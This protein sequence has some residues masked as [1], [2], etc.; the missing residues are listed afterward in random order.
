MS[1]VSQDLLRHHAIDLSQTLRPVAEHGPA[2]EDCRPEIPPETVRIAK[3]M[4]EQSHELHVLQWQAQKFAARLSAE[5]EM[6]PMPLP[7]VR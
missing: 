7:H 1:V 6:P 2:C 4:H 3:Y 5:P